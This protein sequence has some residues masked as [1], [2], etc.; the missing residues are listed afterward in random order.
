MAILMNFWARVGIYVFVLKLEFKNRKPC[1]AGGS[2]K[3]IDEN[4]ISEIFGP[5]V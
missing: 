5:G 1:V 3:I 2:E 4:N